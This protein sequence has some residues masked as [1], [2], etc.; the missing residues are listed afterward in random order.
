MF[1]L[2]SM[3]FLRL[4]YRRVHGILFL[5]IRTPAASNGIS[6]FAVPELDFVFTEKTLPV[7]CLTYCIFTRSQ[8]GVRLLVSCW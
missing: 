7:I 5:W 8:T 3:N 6:F 4:S 1:G 2:V